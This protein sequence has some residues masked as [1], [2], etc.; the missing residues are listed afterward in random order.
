MILALFISTALYLVVLLYTGGS[1][2]TLG[3]RRAEITT[4]VLMLSAL[5]LL[6]QLLHN[7]P[8]I[9]DA[10]I[11]IVLFCAFHILYLANFRTR[12]ATDTVP[13]R[14]LPFS[15]IREL[16]FDLDEFQ[17]LYP[18]DSSTN[19]AYTGAHYVSAYPVGAA[20]LAT[21]IY[22]IS[23]FGGV[24]GSQSIVLELEKLSGATFVALSAVVLYLI[25]I[26]LT[27]RRLST[28]LTVIY[29]LGTSSFSVSSQALWQHGASQL[30][31][32]SA[33]Y[34]LVRGRQK[35]HWIPYAGF[36]CAFSVVCRPTDLLIA[37]PISFW[38]LFH[39]RKS[40]PKYVLWTLPSVAFYVWYNVYYFRNPARTQFEVQESAF[41]DTPLLEG[42]ANILVSP[43]RGLLIYSP[44]FLFSLLGIILIWQK[45]EHIFLRYLTAGVLATILI[46][47]KY[48]A[49]WGG[50]TYGPRLL[51]DI[52]PILVLFLLP[53][54]RLLQRSKAALSV[55]ILLGTFSIA[56]HANGTYLDDGTWNISVDIDQYPER[57]WNWRD[58]QLM[59]TPK[60]WIDRAYIYLNKIPTSRSS[61]EDVGIYFKT[62]LPS[63][64]VIF[65]SQMVRIH[66][67]ATNI[68]KV[69]LLSYP[70]RGEGTIRFHWSWNKAKNNRVQ[71]WGSLR[72][73]TDVF[74]GEKQVM[75][76]RI[77]APEKAGEYIFE[78]QFLLSPSSEIPPALQIPVR[79]VAQ[80]Q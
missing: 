67:E 60:R 30:A 76:L 55:F 50:F 15:I 63:Y 47:A 21:P 65:P 56:A 62:D 14:Y 16:D 34:C 27:D 40:F 44:I 48:H 4:P 10:S 71:H 68:G 2:H 11:P 58:N 72:L 43:G 9:V 45:K 12:G 33:I 17:N 24:K 66:M 75:D 19:I 23:A 25:L 20:I 6:R 35:P 5:M 29:A 59:N 52:T 73:R 61:P 78:M 57:S 38:V 26:Q 41:W 46:Y 77:F 49:W 69:V 80:S 39:Y 74:P 7:G 3:V 28:I 36:P 42:L 8:G 51:A 70:N 18:R 53:L 22:L 37:L 32:V 1:I 13:A 54:R 31:I 64:M 79:I